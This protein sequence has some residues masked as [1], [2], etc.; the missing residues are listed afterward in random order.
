MILIVSA[1]HDTHALVVADELRRRGLPVTIGDVSEFSSGATIQ[2]TTQG[3][4]VGRWIRADGSIIDLSTVTCVWCRRIFPPDYD[5]GLMDVA[6]R[7]FVQRQWTEALWGA[8]LSLDAVLV[9]DPFRQKAASKPYQLALARRFGLKIPETLVT[10]DR[11]CLTEFLNRHNGQVIHKTLAVSD[12]QFLYTKK[13]EADDESA[14]TELILAPMIFQ[15]VVSGN[16]EVRVTIVG[17]RMFA[18]E[19]AP[20]GHVDGRL[21][22]N[23]VYRAHQLPAYLQHRLLRLMRALGLSYSTVDLRIDDRGDY[24]FLDL[25]PQGQYL[26]VEIRTGQPITSALADLLQDSHRQN[27]DRSRRR[28]AVESTCSVVGR[29]ELPAT[30]RLAGRIEDQVC[31]R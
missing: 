4:D 29:S 21:D 28:V 24:I 31:L 20:T 7:L 19:F 11:R 25:N 26:F 30:S 5:A 3:Q 1:D 2:L 12:E 18:A 16:V 22:N 14:L 23:A 6:D 13:W 10:N 15:S 27:E 17:E 9:S 8:L